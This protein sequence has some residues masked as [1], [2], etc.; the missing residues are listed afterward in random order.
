MIINKDI[1]PEREIYHLG[2]LVIEIL[3]NNPNSK[4]DFFD[5]YQSL[6][7]RIKVSVNLYILT[8]DWLYI[9]GLIHKKRETIIKCF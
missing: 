3:S 6:N 2:A 9:L 5:I 4:M 1:N 8:L 7:E